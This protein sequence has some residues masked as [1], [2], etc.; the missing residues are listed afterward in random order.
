MSGVRENRVKIQ[1]LEEAVADLAD[2]FH[3]YDGI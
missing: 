1:V 3:F 2:G